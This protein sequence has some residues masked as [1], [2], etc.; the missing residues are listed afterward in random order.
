GG[1]GWIK[2]QFPWESLEKSPGR[3]WDDRYNVST[4]DKFDYIVDKAAQYGLQVIARLDR[5][6]DWAR[7]PDT[8]PRTPP[9]DLAAYGQY[10]YEV[11]KHFKGRVRCYQIWNEPN[12]TEEWGNKPVDPAAYVAMLKVAYQEIKRADPDARVLSAPLAQTVE[13]NPAH[14]ADYAYLEE[15]YK[16]GAKDYFDI[17]FANAYGFSLPPEDPPSPDVLNFSRVLLQRAVMEKYGDGD[18]PVWFNEFGWNA[19]P[20]DMPA[21]QILW[22]R[23]SEEQQA[24][25][26][27]RA[28]Q[29]ARQDWPWA[30]VF[31]VWFFRQNG[32]QYAPDNSEYYFRMVDFYFTPRLAY[33]AIGEAAR[34]FA[35]AG[36][37]RYQETNPALVP[38]GS[39]QYTIDDK[40]ELGGLITSESV[41]DNLTFTFYGTGISL[42]ANTDNTG[43]RLIVSL[44]DNGVVGLPK[45]VSGRS[46][47]D[48][49]SENPVRDV[50]VPL[51]EGLRLGTHK[52]EVTV[53][54][55]RHPQS[56]GRRVA[57]DGFTVEEEAFFPWPEVAAGALAFAA[58][59]GIVVWYRR[60][61]SPRQ[62]SGNNA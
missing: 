18:K 4:W 32:Q 56:T 53:A 5:P 11:A 50:V 17:L 59:L 21:N 45:D 58:L 19:S 62:A 57:V 39:W 15:M 35:T 42:L 34:P 12:L 10:V 1:F 8:T 38:G 23:V 20:P 7:D 37:G 47:V 16:D 49:Y 25:Y 30:G 14:M 22:G 46:Y 41:G 6:P 9:K 51:A 29:M 40:A 3:F 55:E 31:N 44:D 33:R 61:E 43:G 54:A 52:I 36:P 13:Q 48:L 2:Q 28:V 60:R 24:E 26:T 27:V